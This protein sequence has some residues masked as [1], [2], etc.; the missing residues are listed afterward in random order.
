MEEL[1]RLDNYFVD[2]QSYEDTFLPMTDVEIFSIINEVLDKT[3]KCDNVDT[4]ELEYTYYTLMFCVVHYNMEF[5]NKTYD[6]MEKI[7][8]DYHMPFFIPC[9]EA[10]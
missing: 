9:I 1:G 6:I 10:E 7:S 5:G 3:K 2:K 8:T 4:I